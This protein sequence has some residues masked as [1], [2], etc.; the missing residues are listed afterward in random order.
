MVSLSNF[1]Y[2]QLKLCLSHLNY[3]K[4]YILPISMPELLVTLRLFY[5]ASCL[6]WRDSVIN[7]QSVKYLDFK[8]HL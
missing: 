4:V 8:G 5:G 6:L 3:L 2:F 7:N 1:N